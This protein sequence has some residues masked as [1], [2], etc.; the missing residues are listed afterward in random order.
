VF[1][2]FSDPPVARLWSTDF[3]VF[4]RAYWRGF[5]SLLNERNGPMR[6]S[7]ILL[8]AAANNQVLAANGFTAPGYAELTIWLNGRFN[9]LTGELTSVRPNLQL[10]TNNVCVTNQ[11][12]FDLRGSAPI[13]VVLVCT[14]GSALPVTWLNDT[15]W[16]AAVGLSMGTNVF[17][18]EGYNQLTNKLPA[19][20]PETYTVTNVVIRY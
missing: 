8:V 14:N 20:G 7:R 9:S 12:T 10:L 11:T 1:D 4:R 17:T 18:V 6:P 5:W 2:Q 16:V 19:Y 15:E 3:S 13:E